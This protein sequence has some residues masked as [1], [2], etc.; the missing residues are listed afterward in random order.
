M[1]L[2]NS[3]S[4]KYVLTFFMSTCL[5]TSSFLSTNARAA[6][7][8]D[9]V[10]KTPAWEK[11]NSKQ[12]QNIW[13]DFTPNEKIKK[14]QEADLVPSFT[15]AQGDL[16]IKYKETDL[17]SFLDNTRY[18]ARQARAEILLYV[19][20]VKQ[21]DFDTKK[22]EYINQG[23]VPTDIEAA[24]NLGISY[25][26]SKID[27]NVEKDQKVR[28][29]EKDKKAVIDLYISSIN[30][31]IKYKHYVDNNIIPEMKE[32]RTALNMNKDDAE[33]FV[34]SIRTE[35]M[36]NA[37]GQYIAD[38]HIP[39]EKE[40]KNR[41]GISRADNRDG[42]IKSIRLKVMDKEKPQYIADNSIPTEKEL[43]QKFGADKGEAK[44]YIASIATQMMLNKKAYY[45]DN[46]IIPT[47]EE[48]KEEFKIGTIKANS[49]I[50]QIT[51][52]I[53]AN[54]ILNNNDTTKPS[55]GHSQKKS[56]TKSDNWYISNQG[57]NNTETPSWVPPT[58][59]KEK[60]PYFFDP[61]S[62]FKTHFNN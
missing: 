12:Q 57:T 61:I 27:N 19:E 58:D 4:K 3:H 1:N 62:T 51:T 16:G 14:W 33:S 18:K 26:P 53:N 34:M 31:N 21:Q 22:Q 42:Y 36:E 32:V 46:N 10:S 52:G 47:V 60:Q 15:Q 55:A 54:Q 45:I 8:K 30:R 40:L 35:I 38:S 9:L 25:D 37:K 28:R 43:E 13:K 24:T 6:S 39:T 17:S 44:N 50:Q 23:V 5:L 11:Y 41:F 59:R 7:F 2:Q 49:Y 20:R 56:G 29:A 48:L